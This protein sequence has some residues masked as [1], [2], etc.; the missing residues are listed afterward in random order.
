[1]IKSGATVAIRSVYFQTALTKLASTCIAMCLIAHLFGGNGL[2]RAEEYPAAGCIKQL[3]LPLY[4]S[5]P[6]QAQLTGT[7][8]ANMV[9]GSTGVVKELRVEGPHAALTE[10]VRSHLRNATFLPVCGSQTIELTFSYHLEGARHELP[11]NQ[12]VIKYP[13]TFEV[14][15]F[16]PVLHMSVD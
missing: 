10:W 3:S 13:G 2:L 1:M 12:V 11:D 4:G 15:A 6:W 14:T 7:V 5:L 9:L 8:R 16:P